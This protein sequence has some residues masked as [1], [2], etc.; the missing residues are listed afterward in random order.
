MA[1]GKYKITVEKPGFRTDAA[2]LEL[3]V[4]TPATLNVQLSLGAVSETV[5]VMAE[6][7]TINTQNAAIGSPFNETQVREIPLQTR[8]VVSLLGIQA[9]VSSS[10]QETGR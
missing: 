2:E 10:G 1:P 6:T 9:G 5:N 4:E 7:T 8:N 3:L